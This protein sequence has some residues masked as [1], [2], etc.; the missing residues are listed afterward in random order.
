MKGSI[1]KR[2][3]HETS[4]CFSTLERPS[5]VV[6]EYTVGRI[7]KKRNRYAEYLETDPPLP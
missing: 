6:S 4:Q 5:P 2:W 3:N 1:L 7:L